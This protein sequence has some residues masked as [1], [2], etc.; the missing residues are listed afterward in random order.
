M[1]TI[2]ICVIGLLGFFCILTLNYFSPFLKD[3]I[4]WPC[5]FVMKHFSSI[6]KYYLL[7]FQCQPSSPSS[8]LG[9]KNCFILSQ[10]TFRGAIRHQQKWTWTCLQWDAEPL[11]MPAGRRLTD[12]FFWLH[13]KN[14]SSPHLWRF[15]ND[16]SDVSF[17]WHWGT[18]TIS[19]TLKY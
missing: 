18:R 15:H 12:S 7:V 2:C 9:E 5:I 17:V 8:S 10:V 16:L 3:G 4:I 6:Q 1:H 14:L 13:G 19:T 11:S